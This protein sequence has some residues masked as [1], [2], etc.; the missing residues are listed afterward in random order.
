MN[1]YRQ[2][3]IL[4]AHWRRTFFRIILPFAMNL[5]VTRPRTQRGP[6]DLCP[7]LHRHS[8]IAC[9]A[10]Q[11][12]VNSCCA[13][14]APHRMRY[15]RQGMKALGDLPFF[16]PST[17]VVRFSFSCP[18]QPLSFLLPAVLILSTHAFRCSLEE[19]P[20]VLLT[21]FRP[22][23][24]TL[25]STA[26]LFLAGAAQVEAHITPWARGVWQCNDGKDGV[27]ACYP[28][29]FGPD[30]LT[31]LLRRTTTCLLNP[32]SSGPCWVRVVGGS[33]VMR[34]VSPL[35]DS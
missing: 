11:P 4:N 34:Y 10:D 7:F 5:A 31:R 20:T 15:K 16:F 3:A 24:S 17:L 26:I 6:I 12:R 23:T 21:M 9:F 33:T 18:R 22:S 8:H 32:Y 28:M 13:E 2:S 25:V 19:Q 35:S 29:R 14:R 30:L 1:D 27:R